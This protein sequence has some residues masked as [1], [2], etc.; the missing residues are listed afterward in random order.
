MLKTIEPTPWSFTIEFDE[1]KAKRN[2][3]DI[4]TLYDYTD[5]NVSRYGCVRIAQVRA[6]IGADAV[7]RGGR[8]GGESCRAA[9]GLGIEQAERGGRL[10]RNQTWGANK[11]PTGG[12][13]VQSC[14]GRIDGMRIDALLP[15]DPGITAP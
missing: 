5:R 15:G 10:G 1:D 8:K 11:C 14:D 9:Q 3:Y 2:G 4:Q 12:V 7:G 6:G 13:K